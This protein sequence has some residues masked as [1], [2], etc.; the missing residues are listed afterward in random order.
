MKKTLFIVAA[1]ILS[2]LLFGALDSIHPFG[3]PGKVPMDEYFLHHALEDRSSENVVTS[4]VFD[5]RGFDTIG[6]AAV[7]FTA[8]CSVLALFR[9]GAS[10]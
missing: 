1:L 3:E 4:I 10:K 5:Y 9:E 7:L 6:E 8:V 2:G